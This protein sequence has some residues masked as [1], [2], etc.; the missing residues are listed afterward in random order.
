[1]RWRRNMLYLNGHKVEVT[2]FPDGTSQVWKLPEE[3]LGVKSNSIK[4]DFSH[5][6][7]LFHLMQLV[8]LLKKIQA[9]VPRR[10]QLPYLPY[11]RQDKEVSNTS[12]FALKLFAECIDSLGFWSV[13][14]TDPHSKVA[15]EYI[16]NSYAIY[17]KDY[18]IYVAHSIG[19]EEVC[20]PDKGARDKYVKEYNLKLPI[21]FGSK[22]R[23][24][25]TGLIESYSVEVGMGAE[26]KGKIVLVVDDICDGGA[27]FSMLAE[28]LYKLGAKEVN[29]FITHGI[30][31]KGLTPLHNAG[32][33]NIFTF[34][35]KVSEVQNHITYK[36][37]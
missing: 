1:M 4:W 21:S 3:M 22:V 32:I 35:G 14:I 26:I 9:G 6:G 2:M 18:L 31:S 27:T 10:L 33:K 11:G 8:A 30:F 19:A 5:E 34:K 7:E 13:E 25:T 28:K 36:E 15:L 24:Q 20:Y 37:I 16:Q 12:T 29:L 23:N 17:P